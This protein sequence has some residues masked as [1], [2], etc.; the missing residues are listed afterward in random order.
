MTAAGAALASNVSNLARPARS[1]SRDPVIVGAFSQ[2]PVGDQVPTGWE[3]QSF[4]SI[5]KRTEYA[6]VE[7]EGTVVLQ[8]ISEASSS[9]YTRRVEGLELR[10]TPLLRWRWRVDEA[11][12]NADITQENGDACSAR[13]YVTFGRVLL[14][15]RA[16]C[17][18]W[19]SAPEAGSLVTSP[20]VD[21]VKN[22]VVQDSTAPLNQWLQEERNVFQ[23]FRDAFGETPP[24]PSGV[25]L[26][27]DGF[28]TEERV[29][30][31]YGDITFAP[32]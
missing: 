15:T 20:I 14:T 19:T 16:L 30:A 1:Q 28:R 22:I 3:V 27:T 4:R 7:N 23:D 6:F 26:L 18:A 21:A 31:Y 5:P 2:E 12:Q 8:A 17:Y 9:G 25:A 13:V 32:L 11:V 24:D 10:R 29:V